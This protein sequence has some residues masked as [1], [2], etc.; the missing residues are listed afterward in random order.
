MVLVEGTILFFA[1]FLSKLPSLG[2]KSP[3]L[4]EILFT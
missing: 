1:V 4:G 2:E 3:T